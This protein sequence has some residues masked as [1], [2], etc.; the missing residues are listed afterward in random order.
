M[1]QDFP[2]KFWQW[3][4]DTQTRLCSVDGHGQMSNHTTR[5][6]ARC[7]VAKGI[8]TWSEVPDD[9]KVAEK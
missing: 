1:M 3:Y 6:L 8:I 4:A 9:F 5:E 2:I 7:A